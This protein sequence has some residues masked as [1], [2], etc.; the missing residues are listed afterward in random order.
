MTR[1][2]V[3]SDYAA[4]YSRPGSGRFDRCNLFDLLDRDTKALRD[5]CVLT[6]HVPYLRA[7]SNILQE[8]IPDKY[9]VLAKPWKLA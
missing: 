9:V 5:L 2:G 3:V 4:D 7:F 1:A 8:R 6:F